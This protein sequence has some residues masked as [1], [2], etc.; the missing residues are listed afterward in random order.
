[1]VDAILLSYPWWV[2]PLGI[3]GLFTVA[4]IFVSITDID[5]IFGTLLVMFNI[6]LFPVMI[7]AL[8]I[9]VAIRLLGKHQSEFDII[10][11]TEFYQWL[12]TKMFNMSFEQE[13]VEDEWENVFGAK[14]PVYHET[15]YVE[16]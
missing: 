2:Y 11:F 1:M 14:T 5:I 6:M 4:L 8:F 16:W 9:L 7:V 15:T 13:I 12:F 3:I 10:P